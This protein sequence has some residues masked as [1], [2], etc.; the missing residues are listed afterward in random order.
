M[1]PGL[2]TAPMRDD[3]YANLIKIILN[4]HAVQANEI[5]ARDVFL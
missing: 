4:R 3:T 1:S 2:R 5:G